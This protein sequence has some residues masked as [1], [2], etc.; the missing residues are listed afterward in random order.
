MQ[1]TLEKG[2]WRADYER[3]KCSAEEA[4]RVIQSGDHV[5]VHSN[6]AVPEC[7]VDAM[8][9]RA[10]E[11]RD[12][13]VLHLL[14]L[15]KAEYAQEQYQDSFRVKALFIGKNIRDAVNEGRAEYM[16]IFLS[17]IP[18]LFE[19]GTVPVDVCLIQV[20]PPDAHGF[21]SYGVS[22]DC[23]IA[24]RKKAR[25]VLA[26]VNKQMPRTL[27]RSFV[28][29]SRLDRIVETDRPLPELIEE[30]CSEVEELI[31]L[32]VATLVEDEATIQLGI[33]TIPNAVLANLDE[34]RNLGVHSEMLSDNI[35]DLIEKGIVTND[36]KTVLPGKVAVSFVLGTRRLYDFIDNNP[37]IEFQT[38]DFIN[39]PFVISRNHKMTAINSA[40]QVDITGQVAADSIGSYLYS[41]FGGQVDFIRG[42]SRSPG[43][44]A[45]IVM[46]STARGGTVSRITTSLSPGSGVVTS[47]AD[48]H[49]VVTEYG[50]AQL[51]GRSLKERTRELIRIAHPAFREELEHGCR[52][53]SW[54][55]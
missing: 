25:F 32:N 34:K 17:E 3:K 9:G 12:V 24:A 38:S 28:H 5:Y 19:S 36:A 11:L 41:G 35:V 31:G 18:R 20:S 22:V 49:Y 1:G 13:T 53:L 14:T 45:I 16:P 4:V 50:V 42:A 33:G 8:V 23:T 51:Y 37:M 21:C 7:L 40:L 10:S 39:D 15:G 44:K 55:S 2:D 47:R 52:G 26:E 6:A 54:L 30:P 27:G 29:V 43:G 46:P 48:V